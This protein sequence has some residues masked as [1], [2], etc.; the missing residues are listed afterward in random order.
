MYRFLLSP[1]WIGL[2]LLMTMAAATM[3]GLG[4]WQLDRY[5][6]RSDINNRIDAAAVNQPMPL[7]Q[8]V[9][10]PSPARAGVVGAAPSAAA[11][12]T[13]VTVTG[14]YDAT[15]EILAR[16]RTV[17]GEVGFEIVTPLVL[18]DGTA[19]L[20]DRGWLAPSDQG[21]AHPPIVPPAPTGN[22]TVV[23][24]IHAPE[25]RADQAEPFAGALSVRHIAPQQLAASLPFALYGG[26]V[27][28]ESQTPPADHAFV[29]IHPDHQNAAMNAGY[30]V[31]WL[32]FA[33]LT[34]AGFGYL[35]YREAHPNPD[36]VNPDPVNPNPNP[37]LNPNSSL[38]LN[39]SLNP[40]PAKAPIATTT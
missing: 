26:Y 36:P 6:L 34:V 40:K 35:A 27:T 16:A 37:S 24:R 21:A 4:L 12:W 10:E 17:N 28:L 14:R 23:G 8:A 29:A 13:R 11:A 31:Q 9:A 30:V 38:N 20:I 19:V 25:S 15:H 22:V 39:P 32:M 5:R 18:A 7:A 2:G 3:V 33:L 1:R